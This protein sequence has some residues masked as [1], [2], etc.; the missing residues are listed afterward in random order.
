MLSGEA[1]N[2]NF[3]VFDRGLNP[4]FTGLKRSTLYIHYNTDAVPTKR[5]LDETNS[6]LNIVIRHKL[7]Y[8]TVIAHEEHKS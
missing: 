4:H 1:T 7:V 8:V 5:V 3:I 6:Q 2:T